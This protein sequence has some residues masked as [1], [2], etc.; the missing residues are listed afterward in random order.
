[1]NGQQTSPEIKT[2]PGRGQKQLVAVRQVLAAMALALKNFALYPLSHSICLQ[3]IRTFDARLQVYLQTYGDL[4]LVVGERTFSLGE[5]EVHQD[6][7]EKDQLAG[8]F[9]RDG[10]KWLELQDGIDL[11]EI[12]KLLVI[13]KTNR[14]QPEESSGDIVTALWEANLGHLDYEAVDFM[15]EEGELVD[16]LKLKSVPAE[17]ALQLDSGASSDTGAGAGSGMVDYEK[18]S[19]RLRR[20]YDLELT[21]TEEEALKGM[22]R[23]EEAKNINQEAL[24]ILLIILDEQEEKGDFR[25]ILAFIRE[26]FLFDLGAG[27]FRDMCNLITRL[28][29]DQI[30]YRQERPWAAK[31]IGEFFQEISTA[32]TVE[33][34][35]E[36]LVG[37]DDPLLDEA[38]AKMTRLLQLMS[39]AMLPSLVPLL[40]RDYSEMVERA[41]LLAIKSLA[42]RD[43]SGALA[44]LL[45]HGEALLV[46]KLLPV[47][48]ALKKEGGEDLLD[49]LVEHPDERVRIRVLEKF[50]SLGRKINGRHYRLVDDPN[51]TVRQLALKLLGSERSEFVESFLLNYL[52]NQLYTIADDNHLLACYRA[53]GGCGSGRAIPFLQKTLTEGA[54]KG[55]LGMDKAVLR[56]AAAWALSLLDNPTAK[57]VL[58]DGAA[59]K[60]GAVQEACHIVLGIKP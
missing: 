29:Q 14:V 21:A 49:T 35:A 2:P 3:S 40:T 26:E 19:V 33:I 1:M 31:L 22:V 56:H 41:L 28:R 58:R 48:A 57:K 47:V 30:K 12:S 23:E 24:E 36:V 16:P 45:P 43:T 9:Y 55:L 52:E 54:W 38:L 17:A 25:S 5:A 15:A 11:A 4:R 6:S 50:V 44:K 18:I 13:L 20:G 8:L 10:I 37:Y 32:A 42:E 53:L 27:E 59:S 46:L 7:D 51:P 34:L 39:P 60:F